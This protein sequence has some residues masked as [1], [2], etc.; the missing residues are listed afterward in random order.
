MIQFLELRVS[1]KEQNLTFLHTHAAKQIVVSTK[2][3]ELIDKVHA[4]RNLNDFSRP[5][6]GASLLGHKCDRWL[7]L[8]FHWAVK[9]EF[10]GRIMRLFRRGHQE[11]PNIISDLKSIGIDIKESVNQT[12]VEFGSHVSGSLD[13][14][15]N[16]GMPGDE[17]SK[18]ISEFKTHSKKS[19]DDLVKNGVQKS[20]LSH[21]VQCQVYMAGTGIHKAMY[22]G[23]CKDTDEMYTEFLEYDHDFAQKYIER[24]KRIALTDR[25]PESLSADPSWYECKFCDGHDF[26]FK[27]KT[28]KEVNCRTCARSTALSNSTWFC[29]KWDAVIPNE[30][31]AKGCSSHV[32]HP[33]L[34][35]WKQLDGPDAD[36]GAYE[37]EGKKTLNG[38]FKFSDEEENIPV[39]SSKEL[40]ANPTACALAD[41]YML[42]IRKNFDAKI[43]G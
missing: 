17:K 40:L 41:D 38:N 32:L 25:M 37:I 11:E 28:T 43:V 5:H 2:I 29:A 6:L 13:A 26:C 36:T 21:Y 3:Q 30:E 18:Y 20:K 27:S 4:D 42:D 39:Y 7:W 22:I 1:N 24:G 10:P 35:S 31:Q 15:I 14:I 33:D 8:S 34:V 12:R 23:V 9:P 16:S 19:F